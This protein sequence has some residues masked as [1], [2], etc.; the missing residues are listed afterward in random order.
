MATM[1]GVQVS[2]ATTIVK[3]WTNILYTFLIALPASVVDD[4][5]V[6]TYDLISKVS[7]RIYLFTIKKCFLL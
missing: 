1:F 3:I 5:V 6:R 2:N 7:K 4:I